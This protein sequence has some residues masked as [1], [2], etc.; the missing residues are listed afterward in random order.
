LNEFSL[1]WFSD[2]P[3]LRTRG[4]FAA[5]PVVSSIGG[6]LEAER[7]NR[8]TQFAS[9]MTALVDGLQR[10]RTISRGYVAS[11][12]A[13]DYGTM[14]ADRVLVSTALQ[15]FQRDRRLLDDNGLSARLRRDVDAASAKLGDLTA[16]R[17]RMETQPITSL[18]VAGYYGG[19]IDASLTVMGDL[20]AQHGSSLLG[21]NVDALVAA[22]RAKE[23]ASQA[24][25]LL[26]SVLT[27][28]A[29]GSEE[30]Q[31]FASLAGEERAY[32]AQ[33]R[34]AATV[35]ADPSLCRRARAGRSPSSHPRR[36]A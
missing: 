22:A 27:A 28:G 34:Q 19:L 7:L 9:S 3:Y 20:G 33:F 1:P 18:Q 16:F 25:A 4:V 24:Q 17:S 8:A 15:S 26:F 12:K 6:R 11:G 23:A 21:G 14:I 10:E 32:L 2:S 29:F 5:V 30:Y 13:A 35:A 31:L 36:L